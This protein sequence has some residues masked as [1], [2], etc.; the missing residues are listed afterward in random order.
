MVSHENRNKLIF[1]QNVVEEFKDK[2]T[3]EKVERVIDV[4]PEDKFF[5]GK[6]SAKNQKNDMNSSKTFIN[7]LGVE[8]LLKKEDLKNTRLTVKPKGEFYYRI[9]PNLEEQRKVILQRYQLKDDNEELT[10]ENILDK[11]LKDDEKSDIG[12]KIVP[13]Y[14]KVRMNENFTV[15]CDLG[16]IYDEKNDFG[17]KEIHDKFTNE[18]DNII[19]NISNSPNIYKINRNKIKV[20]DLQ[21]EKTWA[22]YLERGKTPVIPRWDISVNIELKSYTDDLSKVSIYLINETLSD[23]DDVKENKKNTKKLITTIFNSG[24]EI[25]LNGTQYRPIELEYF[26]YDYKYDK[27]EVA[28]GYNCGIERDKENEYILRTTNVPLFI[29]KRLKTRE[30]VVI[31]FDDL[32]NEPIKTLTEIENQM[33]KELSS[34]NQD[35]A[36]RKD[37]LSNNVIDNEKAK[38]A[39]K[40]E[41]RSFEFEIGRF[42]NGIDKIRCYQYIREAFIL[43]NE[44][45]KMSSKGYD[46]WR[47][48]QIVFIVSLI[49][50]IGVS[51]YGEQQMGNECNI[52]KVDLLYFPTGGGK[53]EAFLGI[54]VFTLFFDRLR[55]KQ[56]GNSALIKYPLRLLSVQQVQ[57]VASVLAS[58]EIIRKRHAEIKVS[59]T[60]SLG[61]YVGDSNTPNSLD[62]EKMNE[63]LKETQEQLNEKYK[64]LDICPFCGSSNINLKL[65]QENIRLMHICDNANCLSGGVLPLYIVDKEIYRYI[66]SVII[67]T[68]DKI[69]AIGYQSNFR[70]IL[71]EVTH[72]CPIHGYTSRT[73]CT[74]DKLCEITDI[75]KLKTIELYDPAPTLLIQDELHLVRE[76]LGAFDAHY[77]TF[78]QYMIKNLTKSKKKIKIIG[79]TATISSYE[80]QLY[81]LY[82]KE[83][84]RFPCASPYLDRNFY[85]YIDK[86]ETH[87]LILGY[88]PYGKAII[89]SVVYSMKYLREII[90]S[91]YN[92]PQK[93][94]SIEG[95]NINTEEEAFYILKDYW[96]LLQYNNVKLDGNK[97]LNALDDPINTELE[98]DG[99]KPFEYRKM[100]GDDT[101]QD[102]RR[103]L[104]EVE[105]S[106]NVFE[107]FNTITATSMISHGV[108]AD[109]FNTMLFF[110]MP[111]NTAEYIQAYSRVGRKHPGF[112][113]MLLRPSRVKD[114]SYL[115]NFVK[116]HEYKDILVE[117]VP[118]NRWATKAVDKTLPGILQGIIL[119]YYDRELQ[120]IYGNLYMAKNLKEAIENNKISEQEILQHVLRA[121]QCVD[122]NDT[123]VDL[124][125][126]YRSSIVEKINSIFNEI[127]S[128]TYANNEFLSDVFT[129]IN[130]ERVMTSLRDSD[131]QV[132]VRL[133]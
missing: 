8:F 92:D 83:G 127:K 5:V 29:Q 53:T 2:I 18:L 105:N 28:V 68:I 103:I 70:N 61:Y 11:W 106:E 38:L 16:D 93:V 3:G 35:Y 123:N 116:F 73:K 91:Y 69:A 77:E 115:K 15:N 27:N 107:G 9:N 45:F 36:L 55:G 122:E 64:I 47:L 110:G 114:I 49:P 40:E 59:E 126:Q 87:R 96:I 43:M 78:F 44:A 79:A 66:P 76:S 4:N 34:W 63:I 108:D 67:S 14:T 117:P 65:D 39:F 120:Y 124:G 26:S 109:K 32:I 119:N 56:V 88:A 118:I 113:I 100:T 22:T 81:H 125:N 72:E 130:G 133:D 84:I 99:I 54:T 132:K 75:T 89:N 46:S 20:G 7:Q 41:I 1:L 42:K 62:K 25:E 51:E 74:E 60:F 48:F 86:D 50:D 112:V 31:K 19:N 90:W 82:G 10:Y 101:F 71:G 85:S 12:T 102:V 129:K 13:V 111:G 58:A 94:I 6:L 23:E 131:L 121:Y 17:Y 98:L 104:A 24:L 21:D 128:T 52:D 30:D 37:I 97:V 95:I 33:N 57:R 80:S